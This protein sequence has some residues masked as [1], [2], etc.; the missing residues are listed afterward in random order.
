MN[1]LFNI[2]IK[3][4]VMFLLI[5][6]ITSCTASDPSVGGYSMDPNVKITL[7]VICSIVC[8]VILGYG[9]YFYIKKRREDKNKYK[10]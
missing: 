8:A 10:E 9:I 1:K 6:C 4:N 3:L 7:I 5:L 2:L